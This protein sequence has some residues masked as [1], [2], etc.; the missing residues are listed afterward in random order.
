MLEVNSY[1]PSKGDI[2]WFDFDPSAGK[3][4]Q[5]GRPALVVSRHDF[6]RTTGFAIV[7]PITTTMLN[8]P[9]RVQLPHMLKTK[10]QIVIPQL[11]SLD[12]NS[13]KVDF[14]EKLPEG[15]IQRVD[16]IIQY[17]FN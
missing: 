1:V 2:V 5:K 3:E 7:C 11:K 15:Y 13:R 12:F 8:Y 17:I 9:T 4:I 14:I 10:G 16:Q 6:N